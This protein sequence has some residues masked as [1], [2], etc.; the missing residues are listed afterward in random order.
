MFST[1]HSQSSRPGTL[2]RPVV[3]MVFTEP[4]PPEPSTRR[5]SGRR[6]SW[7]MRSHW[8]CLSLIVASA[9]PP[10]TVKSSP[11]ITMGRPSSSARP[12]TKFEGV[13]ATRSLLAL[14]SARPAIFPIS[15][16]EPGSASL[17]MRSRMVSRPPS[18][19]RWTRSGPP[20]SSAN[21]S[22]RR[23][24]SISFCQS[25]TVTPR[26]RRPLAAVRS[27]LRRGRAIRSGTRLG[28]DPGRAPARAPFQARR[29]ASPACRPCGPGQ[30]SGAR[31]PPA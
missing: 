14:Y 3:S 28:A 29:R 5:M 16:K 15:W 22:R 24:S 1:T 10:R 7:A 27:R 11:P 9:E 8:P 12:K 4:P 18:C 30:R 13:R 25:L 19:W 6:R 26:S 2:A 21:A 20:S 17:A 31:T 23:S